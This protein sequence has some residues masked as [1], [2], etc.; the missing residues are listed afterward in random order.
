M[1]LDMYRAV[2]FDLFHTLTSADVIRLPGKGTSEVLGVS[3]EEWNDQLLLH[4]EE[5]LRG[6]ITDPFL[7]IEKMAHAIDPQ[8]HDA[9]IRQAV[10]NRIDRFRR[11]LANIEDDT[12]D[13]LA[14]LRDGGKLLGLISNADS[15]EI[16]GW[17]ESPLK[18]FFEKPLQW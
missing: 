15:N 16:Q 12:L 11:A 14:R 5:R 13:T 9:T 7:I 10:A 8:I 17:Q 6:G 4:S 1:M 18:R 2:V 3:R